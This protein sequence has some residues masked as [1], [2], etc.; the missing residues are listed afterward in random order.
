MEKLCLFFEVVS[1]F[2]N[3]ISMRFVFKELIWVTSSRG[4]RVP[5]ITN[6]SR[7]TFQIKNA[8]FLRNSYKHHIKYDIQI[9]RVQNGDDRPSRM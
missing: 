5:V 4:L 3:I 6:I 1:K 2:L 8:Q 7:S 9:L